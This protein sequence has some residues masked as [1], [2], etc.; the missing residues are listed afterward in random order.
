M[1]LTEKEV[2]FLSE[3]PHGL[4]IVMD[5]HDQQMTMAEAMG[6]D[7][8]FH[9]QRYAELKAERDRM[10]DEMGLTEDDL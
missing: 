7:I 10:L 1:T 9:K 8:S 6:L 4:N 2:A 5:Y 3:C